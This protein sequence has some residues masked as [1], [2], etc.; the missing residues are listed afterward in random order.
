MQKNFPL[1]S[2]KTIETIERIRVT[3]SSV[4]PVNQ[5]EELIASFRCLDDYLASGKKT[6][7]YDTL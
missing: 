2:I 5:S 7:A 3:S 6:S 4:A 1:A